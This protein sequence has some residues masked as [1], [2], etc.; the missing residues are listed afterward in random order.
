MWARPEQGLAVGEQGQVVLLR[1]SGLLL[2]LRVADGVVV[3]A[4]LPVNVE[5]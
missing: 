5:N 1:V 2:P 3:G 4:W